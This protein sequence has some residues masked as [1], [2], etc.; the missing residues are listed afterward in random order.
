MT[1]HVTEIH[2]ASEVGGDRKTTLRAPAETQLIEAEGITFAYREMGEPGGTPLV[3]CQRFRGT[4]DEWDPA[5]LEAL[6]LHRHLVIFDNIGISSTSGDVPNDPEA[7]ARAAASFIRAKGFAQADLIGFSMGGYVCQI[8][9]IIEPDLV[10]RFILCGS[11]APGREGNQPPEKIFFDTAT[12][13]PWSFEDK[14][15]LF[16]ADSPSSRA[17]ARLAEDR[18]EA[19]QR[20]GGEPLVP[21]NQWRSLYEIIKTF[22]SPAAP[23]FARLGE[24]KAPALI[25]NGDRDP[26]YPLQHQLLLH[27]AIPDSRLAILPMAG[28]GP[29]HQFPA[30]CA[31]MIED[32]LSDT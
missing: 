26:C 28:H 9:A 16:Y 7:Q 1:H 2:P 31:A 6:A 27:E 12:K 8:L 20:I 30:E 24:I 13:T 25:M 14:I 32:F 23:W 5:F 17:R 29:Q 18:I 21:E 15:I 4:M 10:R 3:F 22:S 11:G 19:Q